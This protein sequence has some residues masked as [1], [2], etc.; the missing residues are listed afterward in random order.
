M[1]IYVVAARAEPFLAAVR[2]LSADAQYTVVYVPHTWADL[3]ALALEIE[4][5]KDRWRAR[6]IHVSAAAP[7]AGTSKVIVSLPACREE[8]ANAL[9][10][11]YGDDWISVVPASARYIPLGT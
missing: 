11:A 3:D 6:G 7:D 5:A 4:G 10:A 9:I 8:A 1:T 2:A